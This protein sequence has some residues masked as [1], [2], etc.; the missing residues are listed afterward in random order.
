MP[1]SAS[2]GI[3]HRRSSLGLATVLI[4]L[5]LPI[6]NADAATTLTATTLLIAPEYRLLPADRM[7]PALARQPR[8]ELVIVIDD[9]GYNLDRGRRILALPRALTLGLLPYAPHAKELAERAAL[10]GHEII[11]HQPMEPL[12]HHDME[13][14]TL[15]L[16]MS[17]ERFDAQFAASLAR[18]PRV[19][20]VNNHTGSLLTAHRQPMEWLMAGI[21]QR[22]LYFLDSRTT[23]DSVAET[24]ARAFAVPTVRRDVFL[25]HVQSGDFLRHEFDRG[26]AI[27]RR[28]GHAVIIAHPH[29]IT[30]DFL[31]TQLARLPADVR[32]ISLGA[33][34]AR[35]AEQSGIRPVPDPDRRAVAL[36]GSRASPS[37]SPDR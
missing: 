18:L 10:T 8:A 32:L 6:A 11:L 33:L 12:D 24:T 17:A 20:G 30:L 9:I 5:L 15:E 37:R 31:E 1:D 34:V 27:A 26:L 2:V 23:P 21:A 36:L 35:R 14:G 28:K 25:D 3:S 19:S 7:P 22:G 29:A 4:S 13:P 16:D